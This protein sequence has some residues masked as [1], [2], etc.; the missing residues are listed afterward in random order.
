MLFEFIR[1]MKM[2][3]S[4]LLSEPFSLMLHNFH[5]L[6]RLVL[7]VLLFEHS[8]FTYPPSIVLPFVFKLFQ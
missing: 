6:E 2:K 7:L 1:F 8:F 5:A 4:P 3:N